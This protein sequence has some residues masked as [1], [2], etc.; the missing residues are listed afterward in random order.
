MKKWFILILLLSCS[1]TFALNQ[2]ETKIVQHAQGA[3]AQAQRNYRDQR[4]KTEAA[5]QRAEEAEKEAQAAN[6]NAAQTAQNISVLKGQIDDAAKR[7]QSL[8]AEVTGLRELKKQVNSYW[9]IGAIIYGFE[10]LAK[11]IFILIAVV[12]VLALVIWILSFALPWLKP[13]IGIFNNILT[14]ILTF[15]KNLFK[16]KK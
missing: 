10:R 11:H 4:A 7:E 16:K 15:I 2:N 1:T 9:G 13:L 3:L 12:I 8:V 6:E 14:S 5:E